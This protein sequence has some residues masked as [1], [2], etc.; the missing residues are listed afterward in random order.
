MGSHSFLSCYFKVIAGD[1]DGNAS[2]IR[3]LIVEIDRFYPSGLISNTSPLSQ[4]LG[5]FSIIAKHL[6]D[7]FSVLDSKK[8]IWVTVVYMLEFALFFFFFGISP[9]P[10][11]PL[12]YPGTIM[13]F[14][15]GKETFKFQ[16]TVI[17]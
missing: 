2:L 12:S 11:D 13:F 14:I 7:K 8:G 9:F 1:G 17:L 15:F 10:S 4:G 16:P 6:P 5:T 3:G